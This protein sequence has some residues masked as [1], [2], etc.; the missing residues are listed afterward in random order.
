MVGIDVVRVV[1]VK[2]VIVVGG[3]SQLQR[4]KRKAQGQESREADAFRCCANWLIGVIQQNGELGVEFHE[5][6]SAAA[7]GYGITGE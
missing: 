4:S 6:L 5:E 3:D 1:V 7:A 2:V